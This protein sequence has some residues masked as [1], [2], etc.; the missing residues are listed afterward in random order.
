MTA[1][2]NPPSAGD[3]LS[4][5][6]T[7]ACQN[8]F[9]LR[10]RIDNAKEAE[11]SSGP[12][13]WVLT[14]WNRGGV[15]K[16]IW[17]WA[18]GRIPGRAVCLNMDLLRQEMFNVCFAATGLASAWCWCLQLAVNVCQMGLRM[19]L[20]HYFETSGRSWSKGGE[21]CQWW[22]CSQDAT[23]LYWRNWQ[24]ADVT[25]LRICSRDLAGVL[26]SVWLSSEWWSAGRLTL[27]KNTEF[28]Y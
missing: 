13:A 18:C 7:S 15:M 25:T 2:E 21:F 26:L 17:G 8:W 10:I 28:L 27:S 14:S 23:V 5:L 9:Q 3:L 11:T 24:G 6:G 4:S 19:Y 12:L 1:L 16:P 20:H 22:Y